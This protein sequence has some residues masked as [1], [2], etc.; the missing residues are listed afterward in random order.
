MEPE[1][2]GHDWSEAIGHDPA[3]HRAR[4]MQSR[5]DHFVAES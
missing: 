4:S 1:G 2:T 3:H 5:L